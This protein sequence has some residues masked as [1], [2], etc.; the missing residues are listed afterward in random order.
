MRHFINALLVA[1]FLLIVAAPLAANLAGRDGGDP[2]EENRTL[3]AFPALERSWSSLSAFPEGFDLWFQDH[4]GF[5]STLIRWNGRTRYFWLGVSPSSLVVKGQAGWLY[6]HADGG[7]DDFTNQK[8]LAPDELENWRSAIVRARDWCRTQGAAYLF[9]VLPDKHVI[10]PE[11]FADT[12]RPVT[13]LSRA[14]QV[15]RATADTGVTFGVRDALLAAKPRDRLFHKTDTHWNDRGAYAAYR[16]IIEAARRQLPSV[17]PPKDRS[18]FDQPSRMLSGGDLAAIIGLKKVM[19]EEDLRLL[20]KGGRGFTVLEPAGGYATG[21]EGRIITEIPGA[22]LPRA[23][24]FR[25]SFVSAL[26]PLLSEHFSRVVYLWQYD[27]DPDVVQAEHPDIV[28]QE[29]VGRHLY[30]HVPSPELIPDAPRK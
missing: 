24:I 17:P 4:F 23:V 16:Q 5:R 22:T 20:P 8:L 1:G 11:H 12:V 28:F 2:E 9:I 7:M 30:T 27:F 10:Y 6:Y 29:I 14:D 3:A 18:A 13:A 26:A 25:D 21:G 15:L 19:Q